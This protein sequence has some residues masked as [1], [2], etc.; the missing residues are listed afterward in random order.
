MEK[1]NELRERI[2]EFDRQLIKIF[3]ERLQ[4]AKES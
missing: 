4:I 3:A 2:D 1:I